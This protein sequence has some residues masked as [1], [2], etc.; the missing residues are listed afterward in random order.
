MPVSEKPFVVVS[1]FTGWVPEWKT[2]L[3]ST[4]S[5]LRSSTLSPVSRSLFGAMP[6]ASS[7]SVTVLSTVRT[8]VSPVRQYRMA[9]AGSLPGEPKLPWPS[10]SG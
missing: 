10:I 5:P 6:S 3:A 4:G 9:A 1:R 7:A 8:S 2:L